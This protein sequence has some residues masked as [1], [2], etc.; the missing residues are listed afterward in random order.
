[1]FEKKSVEYLFLE[2]L[3]SFDLLWRQKQPPEVFCKKVIL[4]N[5]TNFIGK[6]LHFFSLFYKVVGLL[7]HFKEHL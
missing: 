1:M 2:Y 7:S 4:E 3:D 5:F 6:H